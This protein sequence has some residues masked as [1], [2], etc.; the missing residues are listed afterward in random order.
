MA[1]KSFDVFISAAH[2]D[3]ALARELRDALTS[4]GLSVWDGNALQPGD[5]W[6]DALER[7]LRESRTIVVLVSPRWQQSPWTAFE[8]GAALGAPRSSP[9][10]RLI[11]VLADGMGTKDLPQS[12]KSVSSLTLDTG[13]DDVATRIA[14]VTSVDEAHSL[15]ESHPG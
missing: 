4:R 3:E 12:L 9:G 13:F 1:G 7:G 8:L 11:P 5:R 2:E 14:E 6:D 10:R 15:G